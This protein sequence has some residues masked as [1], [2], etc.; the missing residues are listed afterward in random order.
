MTDT[1]PTVVMFR[2]F[3]EGDIIALFPYEPGT[4]DPGT[5]ESYMHL[6]QH[7][8]ADPLLVRETRPA[9]PEEYAALKRELESAPYHYRLRVIFRT[10]P[11]AYQRRA[12]ELRAQRAQ[13][14]LGHLRRNAEGVIVDS[15]D[16]DE[17]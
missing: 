9:K 5:C 3:R 13:S 6:G 15:R 14:P 16:P 2:K 1:E 17:K 4:N 11:D 10:P 8:H 7:H 12:E